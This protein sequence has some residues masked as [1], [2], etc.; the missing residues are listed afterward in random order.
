MSKI[1][2][3]CAGCPARK[4]KHSLKNIRSQVVFVEHLC[5]AHPNS[6]SCESVIPNIHEIPSWCPITESAG[7]LTERVL[8]LEARNARLETLLSD[9]GKALIEYKNAWTKYEA[10]HMNIKAG[11]SC[12]S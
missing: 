4:E 6:Y 8:F 1:I 9:V 7:P 10:G 5:S 12:E 3:S 2:R 11:E